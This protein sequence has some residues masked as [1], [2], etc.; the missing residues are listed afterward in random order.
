MQTADKV[1]TAQ[2]PFLEIVSSL[3]CFHL[4]LPSYLFICLSACLLQSSCNSSFPLKCLSNRGFGKI[5]TTNDISL[6]QETASCQFSK[7]Y[8]SG[9]LNC[10]IRCFRW[11]CKVQGAKVIISDFFAMKSARVTFVL[12]RKRDGANEILEILFPQKTPE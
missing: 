7:R 10:D 5:E 8:C 3:I 4:L 2:G 6:K 12:K 1:T 11:E 9:A